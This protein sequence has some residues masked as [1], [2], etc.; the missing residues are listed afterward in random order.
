MCSIFRIKRVIRK[1]HLHKRTRTPTSLAWS[2]TKWLDMDYLDVQH[3][4]KRKTEELS[5]L[6]MGNNAGQKL[7]KII[8]LVAVGK[9][10]FDSHILPCTDI[11]MMRTEVHKHMY[12]SSIT[13][14]LAGTELQWQTRQTQ[15]VRCSRGNTDGIQFRSRMSTIHKPQASSCIHKRNGWDRP[16][17]KAPLAHSSS[18]SSRN[19]SYTTSTLSLQF[20]WLSLSWGSMW[21]CLPGDSTLKL[22]FFFCFMQASL[23][24]A[25]P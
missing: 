7:P 9:W 25:C 19:A 8:T 18:R 16:L 1:L 13:L 11:F 6:Q 21:K 15:T 22:L 17:E 5:L 4:L 12:F 3:S 10:K 24:W 23:S 20:Q 14:Y 2:Q